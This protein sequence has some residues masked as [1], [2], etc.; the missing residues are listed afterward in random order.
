MTIQEFATSIKSTPEKVKIAVNGLVFEGK[1]YQAI[2]KE[3]G[4]SMYHIKKCLDWYTAS[5]QKSTYVH[6]FNYPINTGC[7]TYNLENLSP[8]EVKI[9]HNIE[10]K[11]INP[12]K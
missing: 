3:T 2:N 9:Y 12:R 11:F 6:P 8:A 10:Y 5:R 7:E 4:I 1:S